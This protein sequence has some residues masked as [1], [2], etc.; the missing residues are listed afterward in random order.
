MHFLLSFWEGK[1]MSFAKE[2]V[3]CGRAE[4]QLHKCR[5][6]ITKSKEFLQTLVSKERKGIEYDAEIYA[7]KNKNKHCERKV[8]I[9]CNSRNYMRQRVGKTFP[10][11]SR[12]KLIRFCESKTLNS[13]IK[14]VYS[15]IIEMQIRIFYF[16]NIWNANS[17]WKNSNP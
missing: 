9:Q 4:L 13:N 1:F 5:G 7:R 8:S 11:F 10:Q 17:S 12:W 16:S 6:K 14:Q 2:I 3:I 15:L